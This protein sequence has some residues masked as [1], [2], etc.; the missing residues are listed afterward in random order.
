VTAEDITAGA[1]RGDPVC[2]QLLHQCGRL[3]GEALA[4]IVSF[5]NPS[6]ILIGGG[7]SRA[8]DVLL[9]TIRETVYRRSL[10][11]ATRHLRIVLSAQGDEAAL[12]GAAAMVMD[13]LLHPTRLPRWLPRGSPAGMPELVSAS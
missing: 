5:Y 11:L 3:V 10:P 7:V 4:T 6:L 9:A 12:H 8:G 2:M 1:Q 13:E